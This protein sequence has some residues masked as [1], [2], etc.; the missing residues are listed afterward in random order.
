M[1]SAEDSLSDNHDE[2]EVPEEDMLLLNEDRARVNA[3]FKLVT[4]N[5][6]KLF[7]CNCKGKTKHSDADCHVLVDYLQALFELP[8]CFSKYSKRFEKCS[9]LHDIKEDV[10]L[11][12]VA[13]RLSKSMLCF[14]CCSCCCCML[15]RLFHCFFLSTICR[16][17][18][19]CSANLSERKVASC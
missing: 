19:R 1:S 17:T 14:V 9:C 3:A 4:E 6:L 13:D 7:H 5:P 10:L 8:N 11:N 2:D 16:S 15:I 18:Q 12:V